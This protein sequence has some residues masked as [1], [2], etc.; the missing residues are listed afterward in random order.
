M[1]KETI[2]SKLGP[3]GLNCSKCFAFINGDI[4]NHSREL[5]KQL[6]NF[7]IYA[8]RFLELLD[9]PSF[10]NY[11]AFKE[12]LNYFT[13]VECKGCRKESCKLFKDC[14]VRECSKE[15]QVDFCFQCSEFPCQHTGFDEHLHKRSVTINLKMKEIGVKNYYKEIKEMPRY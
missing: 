3:C 15:K 4:K 6:G 13:S 12:M 9:E 14:R 10:K 8:Q 1:N 11:P 7:D 5:K 2:K